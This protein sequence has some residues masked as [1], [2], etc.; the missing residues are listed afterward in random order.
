MARADRVIN[1]SLLTVTCKDCSLSELCLP[2]GLSE[3]ELGQLEKIVRHSRP[4]HAGDHLFDAGDPLQSLYAIRSGSIK[5]YMLTSSGNVEILGFYLPGEVLGFDGFQTGHHSCCAVALETTSVCRVPF[6]ALEKLC[7]TL[8]GLH[9]EF[10]R[11]IGREISKEQAMLLSLRRKTAPERLASFLLSMS[12]RLEA[13]GLSAQE[14]DLSMSRQDIANYLG[15][16]EETVSRLF[17]QFREGGLLDVRRR[18]CRIQDIVGLGALL[19]ESESVAPVH[20][21][22]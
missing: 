19:G 4:M 10:Y 13:R 12:W 6:A 14:F 15:L 2:R 1:L 7:E 11:V 9:H 18:R 3:G 20:H 17:T 8:P 21:P 22:T 5:A 16:T